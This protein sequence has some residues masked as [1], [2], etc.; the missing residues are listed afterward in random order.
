ML[1]TPV[2]T[3]LSVYSPMPAHRRTD[4]VS[5]KLLRW[6][7]CMG[8]RG[9]SRTGC[10]VSEQIDSR[11]ATG[12]AASGRSRGSWTSGRPESILLNDFFEVIR[13]RPPL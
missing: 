7:S 3:I 9:G 11:I 1:A 12:A 5:P 10:A 13:K 4:T 8:Q 6:L 2:P